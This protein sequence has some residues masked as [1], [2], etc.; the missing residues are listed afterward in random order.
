M[1]S[2]SAKDWEFRAVIGGVGRAGGVGPYGVALLIVIDGDGADDATIA[3]HAGKKAIGQ[4]MNG[5]SPAPNISASSATTCGRRRT[6]HFTVGRRPLASSAPPLPRLGPL[7]RSICSPGWWSEACAAARSYRPGM[8][9]SQR[10]G[11]GTTT[12]ETG[13][14]PGSGGRGRGPRPCPARSGAAR[15]RGRGTPGHPEERAGLK[16][17]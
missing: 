7:T 1:V 12:V 9:T 15:H 8:A 13:R 17:S 11:A 14:R 10:T 16:S 5:S 4:R 2:R 6:R 3:A